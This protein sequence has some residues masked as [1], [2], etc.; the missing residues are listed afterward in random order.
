MKKLLLGMAALLGVSIAHAAH[1]ATQT[2]VFSGGCFW[3]VDAVY[4]H[5]KG[6]TEVVSGYAGG[7]ANTAHYEIVSEGNTGHAESVRVSFDP[8]R[9]TYAQLLQVFFSVAHDPTQLNR[10]GPDSGTQYRSA[11]FYT[12]PEQQQQ[13]QNAIQTLTARHAYA[14]PIVTQVLPLKQFYAAEAHH[15]NYL[16]LHLTQPYIVFNDL[17]KL[18]QLRKTFPAL[19]Q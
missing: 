17:P 2:A 15:Q 18:E 5:V 4:K 7:E 3:G 6:V 14:A 10:Q 19:Y 11:I 8:A 13:A 12:T 9:V 1:A 16:A